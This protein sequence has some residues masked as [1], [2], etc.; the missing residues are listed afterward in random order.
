[1]RFLDRLDRLEQLLDQRGLV[2]SEG[3]PM[4]VRVTGGMDSEPMRAR[5]GIFTIERGPD[6]DLHQFEDRAVQL[7]TKEGAPFL[8][9]G[10]MPAWVR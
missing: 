2:G 4:V 10:G 8:I 7:A 3:R 1:M 6:E 9:I 5:F